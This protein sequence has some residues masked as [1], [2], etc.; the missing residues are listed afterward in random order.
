MEQG[1][2]TP[3]EHYPILPCMGVVPLQLWYVGF[4]AGGLEACL[5]LH[6]EGSATSSSCHK[7]DYHN[8]TPN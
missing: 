4:G 1:M 8:F 2:L 6:V 7:P 3:G 5:R